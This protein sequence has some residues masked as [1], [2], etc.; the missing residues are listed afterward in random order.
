MRRRRRC[1]LLENQPEY[2]CVRFTIISHAGGFD[3]TLIFEDFVSDGYSNT[4]I[5]I[6]RISTPQKHIV[7]S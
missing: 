1:L 3:I 4:I 2:L 6:F 7:Q 5:V